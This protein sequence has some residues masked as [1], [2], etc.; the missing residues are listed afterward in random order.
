MILGNEGKME[1]RLL[2]VKELSKY[3]AM[4]VPTIYTYVSLGRFPEGCVRRVGRALKFEKARID[5]WI[6]ESGTS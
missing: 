6:S 5:R 2:N 3:L 4:P 1:K